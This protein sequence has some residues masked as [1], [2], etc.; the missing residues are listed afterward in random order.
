MRRNRGPWNADRTLRAIAT[1]A[2]YLL[3]RQGIERLDIVSY[4]SH[5]K[6]KDGKRKRVSPMGADG[7]K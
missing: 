5:G 2:L 7:E 3:D 6:R 4:I 1:H